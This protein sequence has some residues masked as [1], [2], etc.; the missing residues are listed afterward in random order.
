MDFIPSYVID[1]STPESLE[2]DFYAWLNYDDYGML[3]S[4]HSSNCEQSPQNSQQGSSKE[5]K[6]PKE[7]TES[8]LVAAIR[9][10][11]SRLGMCRQSEI[12]EQLIKDGLCTKENVPSRSSINQ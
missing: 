11:R 1:T 8:P 6:D 10:Y 2:R 4:A 7:K 5:P 3:P 12:R 9:D